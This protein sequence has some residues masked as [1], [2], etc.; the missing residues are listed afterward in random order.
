[1]SDHPPQKAPI[2]NRRLTADLCNFH[3]EFVD[4]HDHCAFMLDAL[5]SMLL[6]DTS[7]D[8]NAMSA[9]NSLAWQARRKANKLK[10]E[11]IRIHGA[12]C[13]AEIRAKYAQ[14][15]KG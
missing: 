15:P 9:L 1:M 3:N 5:T 14:T 13:G 12:S 10:E 2:E 8:S 7:L 6:D 4:F 11:F